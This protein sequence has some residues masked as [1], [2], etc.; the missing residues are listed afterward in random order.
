MHLKRS[1]YL[2]LNGATKALVFII[3]RN[4]PISICLFL[5]K[6][7]IGKVD[8][9]VK[10]PFLVVWES[11]M[12]RIN[13]SGCFW[14][15]DV[16]GDGCKSQ[17]RNWFIL[18]LLQHMMLFISFCLH[19]TASFVCFATRLYIWQPLT[20]LWFYF[21]QLFYMGYLSVRQKM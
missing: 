12:I 10:T 14:E 5:C 16:I 20:F 3:F 4:E 19:N 8:F 13:L 1:I 7:L 18:W 11:N 2:P 15:I 17:S 9:V 6:V 21:R